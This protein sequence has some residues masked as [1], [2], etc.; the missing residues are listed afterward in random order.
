MLGACQPVFR[1]A[2]GLDTSL[3]CTR[4]AATTRPSSVIISYVV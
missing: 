4:D 3:H 2:I 1:R